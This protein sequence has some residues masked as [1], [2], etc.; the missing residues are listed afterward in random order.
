M[1]SSR[2]CFVELSVP[3]KKIKL[4]LDQRSW[5]ESTMSCREYVRVTCYPV[6]LALT[7]LGNLDDTDVNDALAFLAVPSELE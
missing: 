6:T 3:I 5:V 1:A 7:D 4:F 2:A